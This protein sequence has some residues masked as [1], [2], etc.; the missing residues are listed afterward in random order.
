MNNHRLK[1]IKISLTAEEYE[2]LSNRFSTSTSRNL[3]VFVRKLVLGKPVAILYRNQSFDEFMEVAIALRK[4]LENIR[5]RLVL[6]TP[7]EILIIA[8]IKEIKER[9]NQLADASLQK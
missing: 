4:D 3:A 1:R 9:I 6:N 2:K 5:S 7:D 8:T